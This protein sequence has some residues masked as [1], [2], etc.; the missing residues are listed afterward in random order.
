MKGIGG[1]ELSRRKYNLSLWSGV[2][3]YFTREEGMEIY[4]HLDWLEFHLY[5]LFDNI[6]ERH[7]YLSKTY[8]MLLFY[9]ASYVLRDDSV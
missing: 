3:F 8:I 9:Y 1:L 5:I 6:L 7:T 2:R 4:I